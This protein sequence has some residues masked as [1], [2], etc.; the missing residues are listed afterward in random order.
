V[1]AGDSNSAALS[2]GKQK[3]RQRRKKSFEDGA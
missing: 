2:S 3:Q 1:I